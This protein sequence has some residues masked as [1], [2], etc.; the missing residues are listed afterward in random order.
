LISS[1]TS[2]TFRHTGYALA[3]V[4]DSETLRTRQHLREVLRSARESGKHAIMRNNIL[5]INGQEYTPTSETQVQPPNQEQIRCEPSTS[6]QQET[7]E[8]L[9]EEK[10]TTDQR[11]YEPQEP[12]KKHTFRK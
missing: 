10:T 6:F 5:Y 3:E 11:E 8:I 4:L 7:T 12:S 9:L 1:N 2:L